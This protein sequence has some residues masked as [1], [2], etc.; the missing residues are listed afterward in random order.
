VAGEV[1]RG[2]EDL[3]RVSEELGSKN[4]QIQRVLEEKMRSEEGL[5]G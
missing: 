5:L 1:T 3:A 2:V 4:A